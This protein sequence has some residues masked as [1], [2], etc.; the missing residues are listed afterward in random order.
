MAGP[1]Q[2]RQRPVHMQ[3]RRQ[4]LLLAWQPL[5]EEAQPYSHSALCPDRLLTTQSSQALPCS[6]AELSSYVLTPRMC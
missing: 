3:S 2:I 4:D 1:L 5:S 6:K